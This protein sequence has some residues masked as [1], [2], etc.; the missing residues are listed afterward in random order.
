MALVGR[1]FWNGGFG[2]MMARFAPVWA[3]DCDWIA[4]YFPEKRPGNFRL[5]RIIFL[6]AMH[7]ESP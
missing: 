5:R 3:A 2:F 6:L 1:L 7:L 4:P